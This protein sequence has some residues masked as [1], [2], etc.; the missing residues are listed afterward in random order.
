MTV[1]RITQ[2]TKGPW[3][4]SEVELDDWDVK[5]VTVADH[6]P[7][8]YEQMICEVSGCNHDAEANAQLIC[9]APD[10]LAALEVL[11]AALDRKETIGQDDEYYELKDLGWSLAEEAVFKA[12][13]K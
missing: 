1:G 6:S 7:P 3:Y 2:L 13:G 12:K 5:Y 10:M 4:P 11:L 9:A 8:H